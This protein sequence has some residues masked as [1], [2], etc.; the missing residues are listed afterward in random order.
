MNEEILI[1]GSSRAV[2]HYI[3]AGIHDSL[4]MTCYNCGQDG[5]GI[6]YAYGKWQTIK[7]RYYPTVIL[8]EITNAFD[9]LRN[10]NSKYIKLLRPYYDNPQVSNM[11]NEIAPSEVWKMHSKC[12]PYNSQLISILKYNIST[13]K[14]IQAGYSPLLGE[15]NYIPEV[16]QFRYDKSEIDPLKLKYFE[17]FISETKKIVYSSPAYLHNSDSNRPK[18]LLL[19]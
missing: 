5:L 4:G 6:F 8:Y 1:F 2:H 9:I 15:M 13:K 7:K 17:R 10:D 12:Y 11:I 14:N 19:F 3:P 16:E 18:P